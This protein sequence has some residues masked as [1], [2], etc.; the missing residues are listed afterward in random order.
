MFA[1]PV[2]YLLMASLTVHTILL[3]MLGVFFFYKFRRMSQLL[4]AFQHESLTSAGGRRSVSA[5]NRALLKSEV[6]DHVASLSKKGLPARDIARA[7]SI[8][9]SDVN[10]L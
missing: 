1:S 3:L 10:V 7:C 9:E 8:P 5:L 2:D 6:R 4:D